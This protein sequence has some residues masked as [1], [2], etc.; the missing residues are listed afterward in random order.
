M[1][2]QIGLFLG[3]AG[4]DNGVGV[5]AGRLQAARHLAGSW[6]RG[7]SSM[8]T[9][10]VFLPTWE[11]VF[12]ASQ[13]WPPSLGP[14]LSPTIPGSLVGPER[15]Q[16]QDTGLSPSPGCAPRRTVPSQQLDPH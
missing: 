4:L 14:A 8:G 12:G 15:P 7:S 10:A 9:M 5:T 2:K 6:P 1:N 3:E 11:P 16:G 13:D